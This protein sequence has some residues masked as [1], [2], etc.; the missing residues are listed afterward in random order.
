VTSARITHL[1]DTNVCS[2]LMR[3]RPSSVVERLEALGPERVATS[4]VTSIELRQGA[5]LS[6][7]PAKYHARVDDF[8]AEVRVLPLDNEVARAVGRVR[9]LLRRTG[10]PIGDL[11]SLIAGHA[12]ALGLVLVTHNMRE[13]ARIAELKV[14]DWV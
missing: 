5:D 6:R 1:L 12:L 4:V 11:D 13:F 14:E 3:K 7:E 8:L 9:A 10:K 2:Y